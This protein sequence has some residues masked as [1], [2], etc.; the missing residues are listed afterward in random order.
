MLFRS[1]PVAYNEDIERVREI[2]ESVAADMDSDPAYD[3]MLLGAPQYAGIE[4]VSGEA[5]V[6]RITAKVAAEQQLQAARAIR[7]R[8]KLA[9]DRA[10]VVVPVMVR[11][12][13]GGQPGTPPGTAPRPGV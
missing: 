4:S 13:P 11:P 3:D 8:M 12:L 2:V 5:V 1:I 10:G 9:F 7:E 6:I